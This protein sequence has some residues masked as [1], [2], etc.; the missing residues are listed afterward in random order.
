MPTETL[1]TTTQ[2]DNRD[3]SAPDTTGRAYA[4]AWE[5]FRAPRADK[6]Q[7][8]GLGQEPTLV[9]K[10]EPNTSSEKV[11]AQVRKVLGENKGD[12]KKVVKMAKTKS[13]APQTSSPEQTPAT[14]KPADFDHVVRQL[15]NDEALKRQGLEQT[16]THVLDTRITSLERTMAERLRE[17][18][19][20]FDRFYLR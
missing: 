15:L 19:A 6:Q 9:H 2:K 4:P 1:R 11:Y 20:K 13:T 12:W 17:L 7:A 18:Q 8:T 5:P 14:Q 16:F 3:H 10:S